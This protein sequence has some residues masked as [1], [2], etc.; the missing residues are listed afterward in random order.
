MDVVWRVPTGCLLGV[1]RVSEGCLRGVWS[2]SEEYLRGHERAGLERSDQE[3]T[4]QF[5][6]GQVRIF[7]P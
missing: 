1:W 4:G 7:E 3:I 6:K 5:M 2:L